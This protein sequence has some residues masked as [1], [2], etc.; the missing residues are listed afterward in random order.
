MSRAAFLDRDG[1]INRKPTANG[2]V[3]RWEDMEFL[4]GAVQAIA[5][6]NQVGFQ[7]IV[8]TNQ[9]CIAKGLLTASQLE[10]LHARMR[11]E[12]ATNGARIDA[13]YYCPHEKHPPCSCRKPESGMLLAAARDH[14]IDLKA[15][16]MIGDSN[17][18]IKAGK[19]VGCNTAQ[20]VETQA[21]GGEASVVAS[22]LL[23]AVRQIL[24]AEPMIADQQPTSGTSPLVSSEEQRF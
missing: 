7:V 13:I 23:E 6:L 15:S 16:W 22:S 21:I 11:G 19:N 12:F 9:R 1:V 18:D 24:R 14:Q 2:Y 20:I 4:P 3:T 5:L 8:V 17:E 10:A